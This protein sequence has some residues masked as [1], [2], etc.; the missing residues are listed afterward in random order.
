MSLNILTR[1]RTIRPRTVA[2]GVITTMLVVSAGFAVVSSG[3][4]SP[5]GADDRVTYTI[6][7]GGIYPDSSLLGGTSGHICAEKLSEDVNRVKIDDARLE[8]VDIYVGQEGS[9]QSHIQF[10]SAEVNRNLVL[11]TNGES[12]L[13][14]TLAELG[15]LGGGELCLPEGIPN[16]I[17]TTLEV[18]WLGVYNLNPENLQISSSGTVPDNLPDPT[19]DDVLNE[20]NTTEDDLV[21]E[22]G[23]TN[24]STN[25]TTNETVT[26]TPVATTSGSSTPPATT[27]GSSPTPTAPPTESS[28]QTSATT[29]TSSEPQTNA[30]TAAGTPTPTTS[31]TSAPATPSEPSAEVQRV[32]STATPTPSPSVE[33]E[34]TTPTDSEDEGL[35]EGIVSSLFG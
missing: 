12:A 14:D 8:D 3:Q 25:E 29:A 32:Q 16:P 19:L 24:E 13:V 2:V 17:P 7:T 31:P 18:Y 27:P 1:L 30:E 20:T 22:N 15:D 23:T 33:T 10:D 9:I 5:P 11:Y 26:P 34:T 4:E 28:T 35:L 6:T 21:Y